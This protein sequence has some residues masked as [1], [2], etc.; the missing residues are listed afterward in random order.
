M[1]RAV[2][3]VALAMMVV[4]T[5]MAG[6]TSCSSDELHEGVEQKQDKEQEPDDLN[7]ARIHEELKTQ[8]LVD[9]L[10][11]ADSVPGSGVATYTPRV[12]EALYSATPT[13]C[14]TVADTPEEAEAAYQD[15]VS[16]LRDESGTPV[17]HEVRQGDVHLSFTPGTGGSETGRLIVDCPRLSNVLTALIFVP[18]AAWP[19]NYSSPIPFMSLVR[20][21][22]NGR[23]YLCVREPYG[24]K[25]ILLTFDGGWCDEYFDSDWQG[26]FYMYMKCAKLEAFQC[27]GN[28][29]R[30]RDDAV[31]DMMQ[32]VCDRI[33]WNNTTRK[34][35]GALYYERKKMIFDSDYSYHKGRWWFATNYYIDKRMAKFDNRVYEA[36]TKSY[37]HKA[38]P[39]KNLPSASVYFDTRLNTDGKWEFIYKPGS[40]T[41]R[42]R[43]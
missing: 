18:K 9:A 43:G 35:L 8:L 26:T 25:G 32:M 6:F 28:A 7:S 21:K 4:T 24:C 14:Y 41:K 12:G 38:K 30:T 13:V 23:I 27:L 37:E 2:I 22:S 15:L 36:Q 3:N 34:T 31:A 5:T 16:V 40:S 20:N 1:K 10:C 29:M 11:D 33:E 19:E 42:N 39:S 17:A